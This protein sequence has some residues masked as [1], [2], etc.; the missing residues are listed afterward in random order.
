MVPTSE[1]RKRGSGIYEIAQEIRDRR[2]LHSLGCARFVLFA[3]III[4]E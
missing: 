3:R 2:V 1:Y 4:Y